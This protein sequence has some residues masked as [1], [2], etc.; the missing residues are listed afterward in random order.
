MTDATVSLVLGDFY[1]HGGESDE[2]TVDVIAD[3]VDWGSPAG[4]DAAVQTLLQNSTLVMRE[5]YDNR[6][7]TFKVRIRAADGVI[8]AA[9]EAALF[10]ELGKPNEMVWTPPAAYSPPTVFRVVMSD[11]EPDVDDLAELRCERT[12]SLHFVCEAFNRSVDE[13]VTEAE[14]Q[15]VDGGGDPV[16]P[17]DTLVDNCSSTSGWAAGPSQTLNTGSGT[18][19]TSFAQFPSLTRTGTVSLTDTPIIAVD[20]KVTGEGAGDP[21]LSWGP[22]A[23]MSKPPFASGPSP[24]GDQGYTRY[25][26][27]V[28]VSSVG[29]LQVSYSFSGSKMGRV[30]VNEI[31]KQN[32]PPSSGTLRQ[33]FFK[34]DVAGSAPS[35]GTL[36][37]YHETDALGLVMLY[38]WPDEGGQ[39][40]VPALRSRLVSSDPATSDS[41][42]VSGA[43]NDLY[44]APAVFEIPASQVAVGT[45]E[46][47]ALLRVISTGNRTITTLV[48]TVVGGTTVE[49]S[50]SSLTVN[51]SLS[52]AWKYVPLQRLQLPTRRVL[53]DTTAIVRVTVS[54][55]ASTQ[56]DDAYLFNLDKGAL[57]VVDCDTSTR[58]WV[59]AARLDWPMPS[60]MRGTLEDGTDAFAAGPEVFA[61][62][63]HVIAPSSAN[64][65]CLTKGLPPGGALD[66]GVR[67]RQVAAWHTNAGS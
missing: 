5:R 60:I 62:G 17:I 34:V 2:W 10:A 61:W 25:Y 28:P 26:Y 33:K 48:E 3:G 39:G 38:T 8:L 12:Y 46:W 14:S 49:S 21:W 4:V 53:T 40:F 36:E 50:T 29:S 65:F 1:L 43:R 55:S 37:V 67:F 18:L 59:N 30:W 63:S 22:S 58:L 64:V 44:A 45:Y 7:V 35:D 41:A 51:F 47:G 16:T 15:P 66:A 19:Y 24:Y 11:M 13:I 9:A 42:L 23:Q 57:T 32:S 6:E 31:R 20:A 56:L 54:A 52:A 27:N